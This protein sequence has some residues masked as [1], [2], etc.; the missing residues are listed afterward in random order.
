MAEP[1]KPNYTVESKLEKKMGKT[2]LSKE[3][4]CIG[5]ASKKPTS[6]IDS[7]SL[8]GNLSYDMDKKLNA[9]IQHNLQGCLSN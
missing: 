8:S 9:Q 5:S 1:T 6:L 3:V 4:D 7:L 2:H